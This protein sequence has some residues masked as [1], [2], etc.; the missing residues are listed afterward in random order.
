VLQTR[1]AKIWRG[2]LSLYKAAYAL[3]GLSALFGSLVGDYFLD[4]PAR[5]SGAAGWL[6]FTLAA[7]AELAFAC[8]CVIATWRARHGWN[9][10]RHSA[11]AIG[12][13]LTFVWVQLVFTTGWI[14]WSAMAG[15]SLTSPPIDTLV[16]GLLLPKWQEIRQRP[17]S[18]DN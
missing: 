3:G 16:N 10:R 8:V 11:I 1:L 9:G 13:A 6:Y 17:K 2:E 15:L 7:I 5:H 12:L 18:L 14:G 4:L